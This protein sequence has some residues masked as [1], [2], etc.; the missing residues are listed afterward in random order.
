M[1]LDDGTMYQTE[2][3]AI[4][5][6]RDGEPGE[7]TGMIVYSQDRILGDIYYNGK[8]GIFGSI[9][10]PYPLLASCTSTWATA[11]IR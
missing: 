10:I 2:I 3:I 1:N 8:E 5:K 9:K 6:G 4:K 11:P 7:M